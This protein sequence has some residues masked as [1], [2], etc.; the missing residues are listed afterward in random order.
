MKKLIPIIVLAL[1]LSA[2]SRTIGESPTTEA[3]ILKETETF[4]ATEAVPVVTLEPLDGYTMLQTVFLSIDKD[5]TAD[6]IS[7]LV[8][9]SGLYSYA[10]K[11]STHWYYEIAEHEPSEKFY[12]TNIYD[13]DSIEIDL[14]SHYGGEFLVEHSEY[15]FKE[16]DSKAVYSFDRGYTEESANNAREG[17][18][19]RAYDGSK[20]IYQQPVVACESLKEAL[21]LGI[22]YDPDTNPIE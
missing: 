20:S 18:C 12:G 4:E 3:E 19:F 21:D 7:N 16:N 10:L 9:A 14:Y 8:E 13:G 6:D 5:T 17:I 11:I 2:C 1:T 22:S 15:Q